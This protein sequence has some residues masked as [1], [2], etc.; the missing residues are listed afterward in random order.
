MILVFKFCNSQLNNSATRGANEEGP[1]WAAH[2][3][4]PSEDY[5]GEDVEMGGEGYAFRQESL[6]I[7]MVIG[8]SKNF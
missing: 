7:I 1:R 2:T 4:E 5:V 8:S 6:T 3:G